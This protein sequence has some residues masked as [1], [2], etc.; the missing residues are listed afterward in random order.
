MPKCA[1]VVQ[2]AQRQLA[3]F[4]AATNPS[5][6]LA[7]LLHGRQQHPDQNADDRNDD[8]QLYKCE[9]FFVLRKMHDTTQK[10]R[11]KNGNEFFKTLVLRQRRQKLHQNLLTSLKVTITQFGSQ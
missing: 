3:H 11:W 6:R 1:L 10:D 4:I 8:K 9:P 7:N 2:H 5:C